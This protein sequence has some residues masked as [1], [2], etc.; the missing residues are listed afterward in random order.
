[1]KYLT[2]RLSYEQYEEEN[3]LIAVGQNLKQ[4]LISKKISQSLLAE[5]MTMNRSSVSNMI[6]GKQTITLYSLEKIC[7]ELGIKSQE[8][9]PF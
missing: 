1:M 7:Q 8:L 6:R 5:K 3:V 9:L 4:I 2:K